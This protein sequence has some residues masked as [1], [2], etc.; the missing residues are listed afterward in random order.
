MLCDGARQF[1]NRTV[2]AADEKLLARVCGCILPVVHG[3]L[4]QDGSNSMLSDATAN[5]FAAVFLGAGGDE[6]CVEPDEIVRDSKLEGTFVGQD[7]DSP[8]GIIGRWEVTSGALG[9]GIR[10]P[11]THRSRRVEDGGLDQDTGSTIPSTTRAIA[12]SGQAPSRVGIWPAPPCWF[13]P[14]AH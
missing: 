8:L 11:P 14:N 7:Q 3:V 6:K 12:S 1:P 9:A 4:T 2:A 10:I 5:P 13:R